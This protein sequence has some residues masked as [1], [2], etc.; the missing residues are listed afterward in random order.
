MQNPEEMRVKYKHLQNDII[1]Q[2]N[3][4]SKLTNNDY[5]CI[6]IKK[7]MPGLKQASKLAYD[8]LRVF[9]EPY[10]YEPILD[11]VGLWRHE[12]RP[13][14]FYLCEDDFVIKHWYVEDYNHLCDAIGD[15]FKHTVDKG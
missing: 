5:V 6:N 1:T 9:L 10:L 12:T 8:H 4:D 14:K 3:L 13:T 2:C 7:G 15:T 11:A